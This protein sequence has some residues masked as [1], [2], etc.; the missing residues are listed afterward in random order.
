MTEQHQEPN[1]EETI[2]E[3]AAAETVAMPEAPEAPEARLAALEAKVTE[4]QDAYLRAKAEGENLRRR[5]AE[6]VSKAHKFAVEKFARELIAVS[7]SLDAA[8]ADTAA[9]AATLRSGVELTQKQLL[10]A[11]ERGGMKVENPAPGDK[12]DPN[13]HQAIAM[14]DADQPGN[15]VVNV[16]QKGYQLSDRVLR[17]AMVTVA[18]G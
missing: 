2:H 7:D 16:L 9:D 3:P 18:N 15:T 5:A 10:S 11:F 8:L 6:D 13:Q 17:P 1:A 14:V 12:F 4:L